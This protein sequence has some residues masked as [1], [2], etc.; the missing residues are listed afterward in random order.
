MGGFKKELISLKTSFRLVLPLTIHL[1]DA[2]AIRLMKELIFMQN[3]L[4]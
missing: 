3:L 4:V 2:I 1:E